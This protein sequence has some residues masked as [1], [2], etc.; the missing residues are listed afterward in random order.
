MKARY[1]GHSEMYVIVANAKTIFGATTW[2]RN[3]STTE[4]RF[5]C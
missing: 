1:F 4:A 3:D 5:V 2:L